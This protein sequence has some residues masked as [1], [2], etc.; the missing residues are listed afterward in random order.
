[1]SDVEVTRDGNVLR[2]EINREDKRNALSAEV[3]QTIL[4]AVTGVADSDGVHVVL[5]ASTGD[6]IFSA[7]ADLAVMADDATGLEKHD[8]RGL[9]ARLVV[10]MR[11][12][13][14]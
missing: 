9:L 6:R 7:G 12:C 4:D 8:A 5:L 11:E 3:M 2:L 14:I 10:A 1:M 13:P